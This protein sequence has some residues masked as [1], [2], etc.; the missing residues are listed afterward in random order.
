MLGEFHGMLDDLAKNQSDSEYGDYLKT[1]KFIEHRASEELFDLSKDPGC[2]YNLANDSRHLETIR[3]FRQDMKK[4][5]L[6]T[7]DHELDNFLSF[8]NDQ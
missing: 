1:R 7:Q 6:N 3:K 2:R 5:L 4:V 8:V